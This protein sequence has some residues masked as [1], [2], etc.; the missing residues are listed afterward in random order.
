MG[1][2]FRDKT[3]PL[4]A[5]LKK[6]ADFSKYNS[7]SPAQ[8]ARQ[9]LLDQVL[10]ECVSVTP[11][12]DAVARPWESGCPFEAYLDASDESWCVT[13]CQRPQPRSTPRFIAFICNTFSDE[14]TRWSAFEREFY[15]FKEGY[16]AIAKYFIGFKLFMFFDHKN[17][18]RAEIVMKHRRASKK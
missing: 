10:T 8:D 11:N 13:L 9:W 17:I 3:K 14:A 16:A 1:P 18:E 2:E 7:D 12:W 6:G 15:C 5:Y 4:R